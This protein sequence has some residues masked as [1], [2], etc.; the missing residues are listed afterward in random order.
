MHK[1]KGIFVARRIKAYCYV[2]ITL[3]QTW[4][5]MSNYEDEDAVNDR[6]SFSQFVDLS[7]DENSR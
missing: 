6:I 5:N 1:V 3:L 2:K 7:L 4:Y